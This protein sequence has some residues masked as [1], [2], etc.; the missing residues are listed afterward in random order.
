[1]NALPEIAQRAPTSCTDVEIQDFVAMVRAGGEVGGTALDRNVRTAEALLTGRKGGCLV[2]VAALKTP[3]LSYRKKIQEGSGVELDPVAFPYELG[4]VF[5]LPSAR[6]QGFAT[7]LCELALEER[8]SVGVFATTRVTNAGMANILQK[9]GFVKQGHA[10][11]SSRGKYRLQLFVR[12]AVKN[13]PG[14]R[15]GSEWHRAT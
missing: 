9:V 10:Y 12:Q 1:M 7:K 8:T 5:V 6:G 3:A 11:A 15:H 4:Y 14:L 2:A 13:E